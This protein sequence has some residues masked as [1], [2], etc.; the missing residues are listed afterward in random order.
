VPSWA[1]VLGGIPFPSRWAYGV[2]T[3]VEER[4]VE[5]KGVVLRDQSKAIAALTTQLDEKRLNLEAHSMALDG[6]RGE[7]RKRLEE[8]AGA[9]GGL[10]ALEESYDF[11]R[12]EL[13]LR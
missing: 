8:A 2:G 11:K 4:R 5:A 3:Q 9:L 10:A 6:L 1:A 13:A 7:H 12:K